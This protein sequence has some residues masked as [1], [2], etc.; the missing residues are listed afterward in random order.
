MSFR[1]ISSVF[2]SLAVALLPVLSGSVWSQTSGAEQKNAQTSNVGHS[3]ADRVRL[4]RAYAGVPLAFEANQG[5]TDR[6]VHFLARGLNYTLFLTSDE[7]V[8]ALP[9]TEAPTKDS[10]K[11]EPSAKVGRTRSRGSDAVLRMK[12]QGALPE[13]TI[14]AGQELTR[15]SN[16]YIGRDPSQW[17]VD[18]PNFA[19]VR[20]SGIYRGI[21]LM[22]YG[23]QGRLEYDF[24]VAPGADPGVIQL[25]FDHLQE[26]SKP[27]AAPGRSEQSSGIASLAP[28]TLRVTA[29][30]DLAI[31][32]GSREVI[33]GKPTA[34]QW[35]KNRGSAAKVPV[36][37]RYLIASGNQV[38]FE[39]GAYDHS[40]PLI[41]DPELNYSTF[42][43][44]SNEEFPT[45]LVTG[46]LG[47]VEDRT[48]S[49][50][51]TGMT[52]S[53]DYPLF[54]PFQ[55]YHGGT[56]NGVPCADIFVTKLNYRGDDL[57]YSTYVGGSMDEVG[58]AI[59]IDDKANVFI[60]GNTNSTDFPV[61]AG[62]Y[63]SNFA[64]SSGNCPVDAFTC[65]DA[66]VFSLNAADTK[67][68]YA[69][70]LGGSG[71]DRAE[72]IT[73]D[74]L[75]NAYIVGV[76]SSKNFPISAGAYKATCTNA[77]GT[78]AWVSS[79]NSTGT[80]LA[81]STYLGGTG[82]GVDQALAVAVDSTGHAVVTGFTGSRDFPTTTG[83]YDRRCGSDNRCNGL[84]DAFV[85]KFNPTGTA[86][87]YST[88][89]GGAH[90][91]AGYGVA[92]DASGNAYIVGGTSSSDYPVTSGVFQP[93]YAGGS[94]CDTLGFFCGDGFLTR[95]NP[96]GTALTYSTY[97]GG[98]GDE[99]L[100][101][102]VLDGMSNTYVTGRTSSSNY[103]TLHP[104]QASFAG[105]VSDAV[106]TK[107]NPRAAALIYSTYLGGSGL[108]RGAAIAVDTSWN[109][110][111][112]GSTLSP[113][114]PIVAG[115][116]QPICGTDGNC[117]GGLS[118]V[119][120]SKIANTTDLGVTNSAPGSVTTGSTLTYTITVTNNGPDVSAETT[121]TDTLPLGTTFNAVSVTR[122]SCTAPP[123]GGT[124]VVTCSLLTPLNSGQGFTVTLTVNVTA[125][126]GKTITDTAAVTSRIRGY[127]GSYDPNA[128]NDSAAATTQVQ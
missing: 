89:L 53:A 102:V 77:T 95:L 6:R 75:N 17:H 10:S 86:L 96:T 32:L 41:I 82:P 26:E 65:G 100:V 9:Q 109:A 91:D 122:G 84:Y 92:L 88:F 29:V 44:G 120:V 39:L 7:A 94:S 27:A 45:A 118:D 73:I 125:S 13:A 69:T 97:L 50:Y 14:H 2:W 107:L 54:I 71:D 111:I 124:G 21:D 28:S 1:T 38:Q 98:S 68:N 25:A 42:M 66:F 85:T 11:A 40:R 61:T 113:D 51:F 78:C 72:G 48:G 79:L 83:A 56:C 57:M 15:K 127:P 123:V 58:N 34:Y 63:Q 35:A 46:K 30:G 52:R 87:M 74:S 126:S 70:Y 114:Y 93:T 112:V 22:Y 64:G 81:Y 117:N 33:F 36:T 59:A 108:D 16:Y 62:A 121:L 104:V 105:G 47:S 119:F 76:T 23:H 8:L 106:I 18:V 67:L 43:G 55:G 116:F 4:E 115:A 3:Q 60:A 24:V 103:P 31:S 19:E 80:V 20:Y 128:S 49:T 101:S 37:S 110:Y 90:F 5:Q 12:L 99:Q